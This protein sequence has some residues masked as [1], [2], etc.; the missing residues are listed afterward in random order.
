MKERNHTADI[1]KAICIFLVILGHAPLCQNDLKRFIYAFHM[2]AFFLIY[3][4]LYSV[5][6]H[7]QKGFFTKTFL[8]EKVKRL[9]IPCYI[10]GLIYSLFSSSGI[11]AKSILLIL[12]GSQKAY[13]MAD[14]LT[15]LWFL[16]CMFVSV[17]CVELFMQYEHVLRTWYIRAFIVCF[18]T[19]ISVVLPDFR[20]GYPYSVDV[21]MMGILL[22]YLGYMA[23]P[24][25]KRI[26]TLKTVSLV[27]I[28]GVV[29][30]SCFFVNLLN[31]NYI[32]INNA[33]MAS[34]NYGN[35]VLYLFSGCMG[36]LAIYLISECVSRSKLLWFKNL[37]VF[38][39]AHTLTILLLHKPLIIHLCHVASSLPIPHVITG[40]LS[41][42][43]VFL[44]LAYGMKILKTI[45][46]KS[47]LL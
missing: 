36:S 44:L 10:C 8:V 43:C 31:L 47:F 33:D 23:T 38:T 12:Y 24:L 27:A 7:A 11:S 42:I 37:L 14:S 46:N 21:A 30:V 19:I 3:G 26:T 17:V 20:Y 2:P 6:K 28:S 4:F 25:I 16:P 13:S 29:L 35:I 40:F 45:T 39:G 18:L 34:R 15:S 22:I 1:Y 9:L 32:S 41:G 5:P